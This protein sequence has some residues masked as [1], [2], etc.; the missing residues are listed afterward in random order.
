MNKHGFELLRV[1]TSKYIGSNI[2]VLLHR[3]H[4][5]VQRTTKLFAKHIN[6]NR[7]EICKRSDHL[8]P[9]QRSCSHRSNWERPRVKRYWR[10]G[11]PPIIQYEYGGFCSEWKK[12]NFRSPSKLISHGIISV[13]LFFIAI[14]QISNS[15]NKPYCKIFQKVRKDFWF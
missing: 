11:G 7:L 8:V 12:V 15:K 1:A 6:S 2:V 3:R 5:F 4:I 10:A 13:R 14:V 9:R